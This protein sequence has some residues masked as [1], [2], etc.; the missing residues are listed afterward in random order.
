MSPLADLMRA[1][2][3]PW[4]VAATVFLE[5]W[6]LWFTLGRPFQETALLA[7]SA[8]GASL[9]GFW[10]LLASGALGP[11]SGTEAVLDP[12]LAGWL[13]ACAASWLMACAVEAAVVGWIMRRRRRSWRW[14]R[15]DLGAL[16]AVHLAYV[17]I[18]ALS[19]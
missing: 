9:G 16:G 5:W 13:G 11:L 10:A 12:G 6:L 4:M 7:I 15:Y 17:L 3:Q 1:T 8:R 14:N 18:A 2:L 19:T